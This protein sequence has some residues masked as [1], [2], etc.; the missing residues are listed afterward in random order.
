MY[1]HLGMGVVVRE[2]DVVGIFDMENTTV[3]GATRD[4]LKRA[5]KENLVE[6]VCYDLPRSIVVCRDYIGGERVYITQIAPAT[7]LKRSRAEIGG[8]A[9][10][11]Q[12]RDCNRKELH[13]CSISAFLPVRIAKSMSTLFA[14]GD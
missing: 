7:L 13:L 8:I 9:L 1:I 3:S 10:R 12:P 14:R 6:D 5:Q 11:P 2:E 4:F